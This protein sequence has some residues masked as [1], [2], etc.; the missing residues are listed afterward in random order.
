MPVNNIELSELLNSTPIGLLPLKTQLSGIDTVKP[1]EE[2]I[3]V[4]DALC[5]A[6][7][8]KVGAPFSPYFSFKL[9]EPSTIIMTL[10]RRLPKDD[11]P[12]EVYEF[13]IN[14]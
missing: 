14:V 13:E 5:I 12:I 11:V 8:K 6:A 3:N 4:A 1:H 10:S 2:I 9:K 7:F